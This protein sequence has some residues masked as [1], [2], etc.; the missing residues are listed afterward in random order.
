MQEEK[1]SISTDNQRQSIGR[2]ATDKLV[3]PLD[4]S[5]VTNKEIL[6]AVE[7]IKKKTEVIE[8]TII[9]QTTAFVKNDL[10]E[11]D[12][13]GHRKSHIKINEETK[14]LENYK[15]SISEQVMKWLVNGAIII[16][17]SGVIVTLQSYLK[18]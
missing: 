8:S 7:I 1:Q 13:D 18:T 17:C 9:R 14:I 16:F 6:D 10:D 3:L 4:K 5:G 12:Y 11:P 15:H 2:R